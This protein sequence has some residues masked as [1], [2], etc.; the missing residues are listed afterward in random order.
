MKRTTTLL[1]AIGFCAACSTL[2]AAYALSDEA[3]N[4]RAKERQ[5]Q[6][7]VQLDDPLP[8]GCT[9]RFG[10]S[11]FRHGIPVSTMAVSVDGKMAVAVNGN[12]MLGATRVFDLVSGR[13]L[14]TIGGWEGIDIEAAAISPDGRTIVT[15]QDF[16]L[17]IRN[18][19]TGEQLR[20]I[21]LQRADSSYSRNEW[22]A[23]TPDGKAIAV[24]SQGSVIH[25]IDFQTGK[26]IRNFSN[27]NP[28]SSLGSGW[29]DVLGIALSRDGKLMA[30][31]GFANDHGAYFARLWEVETGKELRR[32]MHDKYSYGI[33][34]LAFS[35]DAK[36]LA[37][38]SHDG[39]LRLFDVGT[40][41][42]RKRFPKDG[43]GRKCGAVAFSPDGRTVAAA[44]NAI[45]FYD[46]T[47]G[48]ERLRID[49]KQASHLQF[50]DGGKTLTGAFM[51]AIYRWDAASGKSL[52]PEAGDS[53]VEQILVTADGSRVVTRGQSGDTHIWDGVSGKHLRR[54]QRRLA[55][56]WR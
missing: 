50:T 6:K 9:L 8:T 7:G 27:D 53:V 51:G 13:D 40:G 54:L 41:K 16:S 12:H 23:F 38:R 17:R 43:G 45:R 5:E 22:V 28:K 36:M 46:A 56:P 42:L 33:P 15:K 20:K 24:T 2:Y 49:R 34:S 39:R 30:A 4:E 32:F 44:G 11:R 47:T 1:A 48:E 19:P 55:A 35:P 14:Y 26:T 3:R 31:G 29:G 18:A 10:T 21:E 52:T 25:L 37:T